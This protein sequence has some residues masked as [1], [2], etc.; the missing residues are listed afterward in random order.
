[1]FFF[2]HNTAKKLTTFTKVYFTSLNEKHNYIL[3]HTVSNAHLSLLF[4][5]LK[6]GAEQR[7]S[8]QFC[9]GL[10]SIF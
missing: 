10:P 5:N 1:M 4:I 7:N 8:N 2:F 6:I 3:P 9:I